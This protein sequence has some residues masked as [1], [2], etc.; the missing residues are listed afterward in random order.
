MQ[1]WVNRTNR[2]EQFRS[3][4]KN[5]PAEVLVAVDFDG[6][7]SPV[8]PDPTQ[9]WV[10]PEA[11]KNLETL[12]K[13]TNVAII[14]GRPVDQVAHL[15]HLDEAFL[16]RVIVLGQYGSERLDKNGRS[17]P[18][19]PE[20]VRRAW[21]DLQ[22]LA[23]EHPGLYLEDKQ[24][25]IGVHTR[26]AAEGTFEAIH[27][28]VYAVAE[29]HGLEI[30]PGKEV[31]ELRSHKVTKGEALEALIEELGVTV[32]AML[33]DD[34]GDLPAFELVKQR[35]EKGLGGLIVISGSDERPELANLGDVMCEGP[36]GIAD[37]LGS[38]N[39]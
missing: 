2:D 16:E 4:L 18:E 26:R 22:P 15:G 10:H 12:S 6:T 17:V 38:L 32:V 37:W 9:A 21:D 23:D 7:L 11:R 36:A 25:A 5:N 3:A 8:V 1:T 33:G 24:Q 31:L 28:T 19:P 27:D 39:D 29:H 14:T 35:Q 13:W 30:E 34:L 20:S